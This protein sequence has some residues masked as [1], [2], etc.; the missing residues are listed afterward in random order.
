MT[1]QLEGERF[2]SI[3]TFRRSGEPVATPVWFAPFDG[4]FVFGTHSDSGK[5]RRIRAVPAVRFA[6]ANYRGLERHDYVDGHAEVLEGPEAQKAEAALA[7]TYGWQWLPF[8]RLIDCYV[9]VVP[10]ARSTPPIDELGGEDAG[11]HREDGDGRDQELEADA[12][13]QHHIGDRSGDRPG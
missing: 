13:V 10:T 12:E 7:K 5:V 3:Q 1:A 9:R 11:R 8:S 2:V 4:G 6:A